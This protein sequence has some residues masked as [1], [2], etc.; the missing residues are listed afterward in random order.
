MRINRAVLLTVVLIAVGVTLVPGQSGRR[1]QPE[2]APPSEGAKVEQDV[3]TLGTTEV[4]VPVTVRNRYGRPIPG[5]TKSDFTLFENG[6]RQEITGFASESVAA[7]ILML[8][9][10]SGSVQTE[11][12]DIRLSALAL[13]NEIGDRDQI[14]IMQFNDKISVIQDWTTDKL[15]LQRALLQLPATGSTA[16]YT[17]LHEA[18]TKKLAGLQGRRTIILFTDGVDTYEGKNAKTSAEALEAIQRAEV[19]VYVISKTRALREYLLGQRSFSIFR[20]IDPNAP[21]IQA[22]VRA[23]DEAEVWLIS[24]ADRT[25]GSIWFPKDQSELRDVYSDI[26]KEL[27]SQYVL[28]YVPKNAN[29][30][31]AFRRIRVI[32]GNPAYIAYAREGY[33]AVRK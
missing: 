14:C 17:A 5:L 9:D 13:I 8:I 20:Q 12:N 26:A 29:M 32:T 33:Y 4:I 27:N 3:V 30:D 11:I 6:V 10:V 24:L 23:L 21:Y 19:S 1:R 22:Y 25:G 31:G 18:A 15:R 28:S 2:A 7:N 16:L